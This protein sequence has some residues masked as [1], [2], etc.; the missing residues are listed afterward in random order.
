VAPKRDGH[1]EAPSSRTQRGA[2]ALRVSVTAGRADGP[3]PV[4]GFEPLRSK[5]R[6]TQPHIDLVRRGELIAALLHCAAP[7]V[8]VSAPAGYG[9]STVLSQW[10]QADRRPAAWVQLGEAD[11]DPVVLL[12]YLILALEPIAPLGPAIVDLLQV[13]YPPLKERVLPIL[14]EAIAGAPPFLLVLDDGHLVRNEVCWQTILSLL[15]HLPRGAQMAIGS[16]H[17]PALP[18]ARLRAAGGLAEFRAERLAMSRDEAHELLELH[19]FTCD[20]KT[21]DA[22]LAVTEGWVTGLYLA[23]L[24]G[25]GRRVDAWLPHVRGDRREIAAYLVAEVLEQQPAAVQE[26]LVRTSILESLSAP[27]CDAVTGG[28]D[29]HEVLAHLARENLFVAALDDRNQWYRYHHLFGELLCAQLE[30]REPRRLT[31]LHRAAAAWYH[32]HADPVQAVLHWLAAG[33]VAA[34]AEPA[35][36]AC[37]DYVDHGQVETARRMLDAFTE[38]QLLSNVALTMAAGW[39]YGTV[40]GDSRRGEFWRHA[41]CAATVDDRPLP[42]GGD[43]WRS[44]QAGLRAFLAPD[45]ITR[46]REDAELS[47]R[48]AEGSG[49]QSCA[50]SKRALGVACYLSGRRRRAEQLFDA[51]LWEIRDRS[52]EAYALAFLSLIAADELRW[53]EAADFDRRVREHAP[54]MTLDMSPGMFLALPMLLAHTRVLAWRGDPGFDAQRARTERHIE[55]M[56]PQVEWRLL[57]ASVILGEVDLERGD[58]VEAGRWTAKAETVLRGYPDA[59][60]LRRRAE[61][62]RQTLEQRR[63]ADPLTRAEGRVLELLPTQLTAE[64]MAARLFVSK[65]TVKTHM[66]RLYTKLGVTTRTDAVERA[67]E[68][69]L[70]RPRDEP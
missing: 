1:R 27:L 64:Q 11:N 68:L 26:F 49:V 39:L 25:E 3:R 41:A 33:D 12:T 42:G 23:L 47:L 24:T 48:L 51:V 58:L 14:A 56:V 29:A 54:A 57:L 69:S 63:L 38:E 28:D 53:D 65:N 8:L 17:D 61:R 36:L 34:A 16:R 21:L 30:R 45:G 60:M 15:D 67:H 9:K 35:F 52:C 5:L 43:T 10:V 70:L 4:T 44:Y 66:R 31:D 18:L 2:V 7:L 19:A 62:L 40:V 22:V 6:P 50:E 32:E 20:A 59:G 46:M 13:R 37:F 55:E